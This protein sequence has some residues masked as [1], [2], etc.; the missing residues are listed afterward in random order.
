MRVAA[1]DLGTNTFLLL[2]AEVV[3]GE[4][5]QVFVDE[6]R[7]VRLGQGVHESRE[8]HPEALKRAELCLAE[9]SGIIKKMNCDQV[10]A[11]A[12]SAARD[13]RNAHEFIQ[14]GVR[15]QIPISVIAGQIEAEITY[16]GAQV[17][18][19]NQNIAVIDVGGGSTEIMGRN[20]SGALTGVSLNI[21]SVRLTEMF[22]SRHPCPAADL[23]QLE[24]YIREQID[25]HRK[26]L[27]TGFNEIVA[28]AGTPT[29]LTTLT[30]QTSF[31]EK[32]VHGFLL[33]TDQIFRLRDQMAGL[34]LLRR[35]ALP[36]MEPKRADVLVAGATILGLC[37]QALGAK[38]VRVSTKG[39][40]YGVAL[41]WRELK[42]QPVI[43]GI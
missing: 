28:V 1:L 18:L 34:D 12:T 35:Q 33:D 15:Y 30:L 37:A 2:I 10:V 16:S 29:T 27:P 4:I 21:G 39:V 38:S 20:A 24:A 14:M 36:G 17:G 26:R 8:F 6:V 5:K 42:D 13:V 3:E 22:L 19:S 31:D 32:K 25:M 41:N 23:L 9:F 40:R 7:V 43:K 11:V